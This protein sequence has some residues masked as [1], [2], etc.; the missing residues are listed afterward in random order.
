MHDTNALSSAVVAF[1]GFA[2]YQSNLRAKTTVATCTKTHIVC[3]KLYLSRVHTLFMRA[4]QNP[5]REPKIRLW[6]GIIE[7]RN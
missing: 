1:L 3:F 7:N 5:S 6:E 2:L 4:A